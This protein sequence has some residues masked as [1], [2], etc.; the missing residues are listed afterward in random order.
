MSEGRRGQG[1]MGEMGEMGKQGELKALI[2]R[3]VGIAHM[4]Y[5]WQWLG[6]CIHLEKI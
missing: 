5:F 4:A 1:E 2:F 6:V 3:R